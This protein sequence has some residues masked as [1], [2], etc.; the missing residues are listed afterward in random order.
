MALSQ[1]LEFRQTQALVMTPQLMQAIKLLQLSSLDLASY[2]E[3]ELERNPLLERAADDD[4]SPAEASAP[5]APASEGERDTASAP[6]WIGEDLETSRASIE[7]GLGTELDNVFPDDGG[8]K[9]AATEV[10]APGYSEWSGAASRGEDGGYNLEAFVSA[11][12]TLANHLAEQMALA[13]SDPAG[14]M[15]G[16]YL[17]D[18]VDEAGYLVGDLGT[19]ADKLGAPVSDVEAVLA[20]LQTLDPSGVCA[21]NLTECLAIQ[22]KDRNRFDP[23]MRMLV[24][25]LDLLAKRDLGALRRLCGVNDED[26][27]DMIA[28]IRNLNPKPGLAFGSTMVQPIVPDVFVRAAPDGSWQV[29]LNSDTLPKV[30]INQRY[31]SQVSKTTRSDSDKSYIADCLQTATWLVRALDQRA[32]TILK[33][34]SE[35]V[36]QQDAFFA[37]GVQH[38]RPLNLKT[39]ADAIG[40]HESTVSRV[41]ANKYMATNRGIFEL[42]YFFTSSIAS[43]DGGEAHSAEAVR[44]R[45]RQLI[46]SETAADVLSDDTIVDKLRDAGI[47]IARRTVAKYREAM[48]IPSSVQRRREKQAAAS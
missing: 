48:R 8:D 27:A 17:I 15:I 14:R 21:R 2:V 22:L 6:D 31:Y 13:I 9:P 29:E 34:S 19:V 10:P 16:Q 37:N 18:M 47:D 43:A 41:T 3:G 25:H 7:E 36:R 39:V 38:L 11:E 23:A 26:L 32:K 4:T 30:L 45:I 46:D 35:I 28:E 1:R 42:K 44:H 33:V 40:M 24:E 5:E 20:I 12:T